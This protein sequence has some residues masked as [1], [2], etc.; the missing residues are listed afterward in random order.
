[1]EVCVAIIVIIF[2]KN[3]FRYMALRVLS[4]IR[5]GVMRDL[6]NELFGK[7]LSCHSPD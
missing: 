4:P 5:T 6:R 3:F 7:L 2:L 1:M